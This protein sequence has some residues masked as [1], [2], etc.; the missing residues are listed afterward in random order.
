[1]NWASTD[2]IAAVS[3]RREAL[4]AGGLV[5]AGAIGLRPAPAKSPLV[6]GANRRAYP[7]VHAA[8]PRAIGARIYYER[9]NEFP[10]TWPHRLPGTWMTLS[11]RPN[12]HDLL[13][14][15]LDDQLNA[16]IHSAPLHAELTFWH[17]NNG[18]NPLGYPH[19]VNNPQAALLMQHYGLKLCRGTNVRFG[20]I[21]CGPAKQQL[22]WMAR[23]LD[24]YGDD[25]YD[26][27]RFHNPDGTLS[28]AKIYSRLEANLETWRKRSGRT[29]PHIRIC[30]TNSPHDSHRKNW[31]TWLAEWMAGHNGH[32]ILTYWNA[33]HGLDHQGLSGPWP[34]SPDVVRRLR[35][36][37]VDYGH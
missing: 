6:F 16:I 32:R 27:T 11:L 20:V 18:G 30:E 10:S 34:P 37:S 25:L 33:E 1:M 12:P 36:L 2:G 23:G 9:E 5:I 7:Q 15:K 13:S 35:H 28:K 4:A 29:W 14:G 3:S 26:F 31:F 17:E 22:G 21:T 19:Y 24:W 8:I